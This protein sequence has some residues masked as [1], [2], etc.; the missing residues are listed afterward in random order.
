MA[1]KL[2][3][4]SIRP[5]TIKHELFQPHLV[6]QTVAIIISRLHHCPILWRQADSQGGESEKL[7]LQFALSQLFE[8]RNLLK[9]CV[10]I[11]FGF[12]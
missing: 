3:V 6:S 9:K 2:Q 4:Q 12:P 1:G 5:K 11:F 8:R 7:N 10:V